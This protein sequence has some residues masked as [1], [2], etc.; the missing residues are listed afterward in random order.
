MCGNAKEILQT[1][2]AL[3]NLVPHTTTVMRDG[4]VLDGFPAKELV[5]GDLLLLATGD[6]VPADCRVVDS[7]ELRVD[8][9]SLTGENHPVNKTGE[10]LGFNKVSDSAT[11]P[12][13]QQR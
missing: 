8:E 13:P 5:I 3:E 10:G 7:V 9:S 2:E 4:R 12:L 1:L 11:I 6:R